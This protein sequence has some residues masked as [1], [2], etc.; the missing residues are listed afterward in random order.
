M[1]FAEVQDMSQIHNSHL[2]FQILKQKFNPNCEEFWL[3]T[4]N[5]TL[6][7]TKTVLL[8]KGT[9]NYCPVHPRDLFRECLT[10]NAFTF[11]IAHNHPSMDVNPSPADLKLTRRLFKLSQMLEIP[12]ADHIIF[13]DVNYFSLREN[14]SISWK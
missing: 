5:S 4:L 12:M 11:L 2:A 3:L 7:L 10:A 8:T 9:L 13:S 14:N 1:I 6:T